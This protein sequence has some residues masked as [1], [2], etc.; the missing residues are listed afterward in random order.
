[1]RG[2]LNVKLT[3]DVSNGYVVADAVR[4]VE[5]AST[6]STEPIV[7]DDSDSGYAETGS[8][9]QTVTAN[10]AYQ[11]EYRSAVAGTGQNTASWAFS[12]LPA[13]RYN[14]YATWS[15]AQNL[16]TNAPFTIYDN[17]N[18]VGTQQVNQQVAPSGVTDDGQV[19]Q[20]VGSYWIG[21]GEMRVELSDDA[22]G[23]VAA[24]AIRIT[25]PTTLYWDPDHNNA[26]NYTSG[27]GLGCNA[28][29]VW[30]TTDANWCDQ[31]GTYHVWNNN[32]GDTAV[33][34]GT[35]GTVT[36]A[37]GVTAGSIN[38]KTTGYTVAPYDQTSSLSLTGSSHL[39]SV[40]SGLTATISTPIGGSYGPTKTGSGTLV[41]S[42][43]NTYTGTTSV[44][45]GVLN[46]KNS[47]AL[48]DPSA[49][50]TISSG[51]T[52]ELQNGTNGS[53]NIGNESLSLSPPLY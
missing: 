38:F 49:G 32:N 8:N 28:S 47:N 40:D 51:A 10:S 7:T 45:G 31:S 43:T 46:I 20:L 16:A 9:W 53:I 35:T 39:I 6:S 25:D 19:W 34:W 4:I 42:G 11:G 18:V 37:S 5:V 26:N 15:A 21:N 23:A 14:I 13:G 17:N 36:I 41:L 52:L 27:S 33:F 44:S 48:G 30:N 3:D 50:T 22:N 29:G 24:D 2:T 12:D 1:M